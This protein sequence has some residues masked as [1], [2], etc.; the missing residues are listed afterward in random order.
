MNCFEVK[1]VSCAADVVTLGDT[2]RVFSSGDLNTMASVVYKLTERYKRKVDRLLFIIENRTNICE[3]EL[4]SI[5]DQAKSYYD[6]WTGQVIRLGAKPSGVWMVDFDSGDGYYCWK[7]PEKQINH[8][9]GYLDG[10]R[11][12]RKIDENDILLEPND[13]PFELEQEVPAYSNVVP[14]IKA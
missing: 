7:F 6:Q 8:W 9:H 2:R 10:F 4:Q 12:R 3:I 11:K 13:E 5:K 14:L 1:T